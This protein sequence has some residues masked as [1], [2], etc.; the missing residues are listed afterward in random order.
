MISVKEV[1]KQLREGALR[2]YRG[3]PAALSGVA[4]VEAAAQTVGERASLAGSVAAL[5]GHFIR[6]TLAHNSEL[7]GTVL[8]NLAI[9]Y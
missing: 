1:P 5:T 2:C 4:T 8:Q 6:N 3:V 7:G 9:Y